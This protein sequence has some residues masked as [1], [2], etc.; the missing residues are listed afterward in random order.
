MAM[1]TVREGVPMRLRLFG[2]EFT[3]ERVEWRGDRLVKE[4]RLTLDAAANLVRTIYGPEFDRMAREPEP[5]LT[6]IDPIHPA[7]RQDPQD[8][9]KGKFP[10][11]V[12]LDEA[13]AIFTERPALTPE[14]EVAEVERMK[15]IISGEG[16]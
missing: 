14:Q 3:V 4:P 10:R 13:T 16:T 8:D 9:G 2:W 15:R 12:T 6:P 11:P 7:K 1:P 5:S